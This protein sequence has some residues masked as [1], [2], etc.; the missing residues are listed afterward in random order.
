MQA[1][2]R[3]LTLLENDLDRVEEGATASSARVKEL[4][5]QVEELVRKNKQQERTID[6][7]ESE[8]IYI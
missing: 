1:L 2:Q 6:T 8:Y 3:K 5:T 4:E 7:L